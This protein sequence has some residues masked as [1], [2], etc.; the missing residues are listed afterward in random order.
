MS[1]QNIYDAVNERIIAKIK[2]GVAPWRQTW[3][4]GLL[5]HNY[6][7]RQYHGINILLLS[8][9]GFEK[10]I[11]MT[12]KQAQE[13]G[14]QVKKGSK[15]TTVVYFNVMQKEN[16]NGDLDKIPFMKH[17]TVF[18]LDQIEGLETPEF[19][20]H[21]DILNPNERIEL[22]EGVVQNMQNAPKIEVNEEG[23]CVYNILSD[24]V[25]MP[26]IEK[27]E[28]SEEYYSGLF[29]ELAH[30][31]GHKSRLDRKEVSGLGRTKTDYA[32]EELVA[33]IT[34]AF[35]CATTGIENKTLD[36]SAAYLD[37][38]LSILKGNQKFFFQS[39]AKAQKAADYIL[40]QK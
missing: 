30:S 2:E 7:G 38:W 10:P 13:V 26:I 11:F 33:E 40:N 25:K 3:A 19:A 24:I 21:L 12:Y 22:C 23:R 35:L 36:N 5:P 18:N 17:Y 31:T 29:H 27:F 8:M 37:G 28:C 16:K 34:S 14:G 9:S 6:D 15:G 20:T 1:K 4:G 39:A 32:K